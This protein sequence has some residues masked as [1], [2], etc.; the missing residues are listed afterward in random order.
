MDE[1]NL[2][3]KYIEGGE[4]NHEEFRFLEE[5]LIYLMNQAK[6]SDLRPKAAD[7]KICKF[8]GLREDSLEINCIAT[9][10][11]KLRPTEEGLCREQKVFHLIMESKFL[12]Y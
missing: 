7:K 4:I 12:N 10:L 9:V 1:I 11:E 2:L 8:L 3:Y 6:L 5:K